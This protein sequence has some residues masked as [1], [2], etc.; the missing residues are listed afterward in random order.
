MKPTS[1]NSPASNSEALT[2]FRLRALAAPDVLPR[3][4]ELLAKRNMV[5]AFWHSERTDDGLEIEFRVD[6][7]DDHL[8]AYM[9]ECL[10]QIVNVEAVVT[11]AVSLKETRAAFG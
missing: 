6:G 5:P 2:A 10:R 9:A 1:P 11:T 3:C 8:K 7:V 4:L